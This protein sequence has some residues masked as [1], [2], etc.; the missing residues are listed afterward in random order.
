[1]TQHLFEQGPTPTTATRCWWC[2]A[3]GGMVYQGTAALCNRPGGSRVRAQPQTGCVG[4][5]REVGADDEPG[6]PQCID[7]SDLQ[8]EALRPLHQSA[9]TVVRWAP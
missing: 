3:F 7:G 9:A 1:M 4:F 5:M 6:P 2:T 8:R